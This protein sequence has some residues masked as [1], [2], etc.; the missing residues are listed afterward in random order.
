MAGQ[1][2]GTAHRGTER[3]MG[4]MYLIF[5]LILYDEVHSAFEVMKTRHQLSW[6]EAVHHCDKIRSYLTFAVP[7]V[8]YSSMTVLDKI[9]LHGESWVGYFQAYEYFLFIGKMLS[10]L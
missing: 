4:L 3:T 8:N 7:V 1:S 2:F 10:Q 5:S 6:K 9:D